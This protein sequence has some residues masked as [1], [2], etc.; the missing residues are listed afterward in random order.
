MQTLHLTRPSPCQPPSL[1]PS[2]SDL[3][4]AGGRQGEGMRGVLQDRGPGYEDDRILKEDEDEEKQVY[5][6]EED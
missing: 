6:L 5:G 4:A 1:S 3:G 2:P